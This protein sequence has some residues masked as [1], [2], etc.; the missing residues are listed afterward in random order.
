MQSRIRETQDAARGMHE[1]VR[2]LLSRLEK[3]RNE[4]ARRAQALEAERRGL[5]E[6]G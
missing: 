6:Q 4:T 2:D 1:Q 5:L 3:N